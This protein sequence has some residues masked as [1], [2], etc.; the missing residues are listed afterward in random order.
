MRGQQAEGEGGAVFEEGIGLGVTLSVP[1]EKT[2]FE[3]LNRSEIFVL[4]L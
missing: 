1:S 4:C 2:V 3:V